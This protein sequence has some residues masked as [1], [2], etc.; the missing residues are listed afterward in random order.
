MTLRILIADDHHVVRQGLRTYLRVDPDLEVVGEAENGAEAV[1]MALRLRPD[2][3]LMDLIMPELDGIAGYPGRVRRQA[4]EARGSLVRVGQ[5][6]PDQ[7]G[8]G[9]DVRGEDVRCARHAAR[10]ATGITPR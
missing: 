7:C 2:V 9:M 1:R 6:R 4:V 5:R 8:T 10:P 3:V